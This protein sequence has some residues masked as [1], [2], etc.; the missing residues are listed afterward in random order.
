MADV[1]LPKRLYGD[2]EKIRQI[3]M[4]FLTN[5][6]KYTAFG[7]ITLR[8][9]VEHKQRDYCSVRFS[10]KDTGAGIKQ[11]KL[12]ILFRAFETLDEEKRGNLLGTGLGLDIANRFATMMGGRIRCESVYGEGSE[13]CFIVDQKIV[14]PE[15]IGEFSEVQDLPASESFTP[16]FLAPDANIL[17]ADVRRIHKQKADGLQCTIGFLL[18]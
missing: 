14:D 2:Y 8:V 17:V 7:S 3:V 5:A 10:V 1:S 18:I 6:V 4:N 13:F 11:E 15:E 12:E 9:A 16:R